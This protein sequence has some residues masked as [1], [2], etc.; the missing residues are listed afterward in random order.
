M[1]N[2]AIG[3]VMRT[4]GRCPP[5]RALR[6]SGLALEGDERQ[7]LRSIAEQSVRELSAAPPSAQARAA[8]DHAP[9]TAHERIASS[10]AARHS[11]AV[12]R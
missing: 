5:E 2:E 4:Y 7:K 8:V 9:L 1:M 12:A 3:I 10:G 11:S 6:R